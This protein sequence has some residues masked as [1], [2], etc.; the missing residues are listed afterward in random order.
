MYGI[1]TYICILTKIPPNMRQ[2]TFRDHLFYSPN[3][4]PPKMS[5]LHVKQ[6][7][8]KIKTMTPTTLSEQTLDDKLMAR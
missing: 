8:E 4:L 1:K 5:L 6:C 2:T 7:Q 3:S